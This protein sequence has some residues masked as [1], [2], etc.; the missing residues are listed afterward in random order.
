M[1]GSDIM[2]PGITSKGGKLPQC[3]KNK[4]IGIMAEGKNHPL[5]IGYLAM[6][7]D[8]ILKINKGVAI[9]MITYIGD[10][11]WLIK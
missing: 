10:D 3:E 4:T 1:G 11:L 9:N 6:S 2:C 8:Q 5:A 7:A